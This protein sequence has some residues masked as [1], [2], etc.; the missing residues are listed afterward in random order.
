[1]N[2]PVVKQQGMVL[3]MALLILLSL[4]VL[5]VSSVDSSISQG[6]LVTSLEQRQLAFNAAESA[7]AM[8]M[9]E[10]ED[11]VL[12]ANDSV[13]DSLSEARLGTAFDPGFDT[14]SCFANTTASER[15]VTQSAF[16]PG[17]SQVNS[18]AFNDRQ[19]NSWSRTVFIREQA[20]RGSSAV[21]GSGGV[22]CHVFLIRGCGQQ[23]EQ[24]FAVAN[25]AVVSVT[26]PSN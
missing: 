19:V 1:M 20:C 16:T 6:K 23:G 13:L 9:L 2:S 14:L 18:G 21:I 8:A 17:V 4:T 3:I 22:S 24:P 15:F 7:L 10:A 11:E 26:A 25:S 12:L 5:G